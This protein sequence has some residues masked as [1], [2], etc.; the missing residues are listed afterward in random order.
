M[1]AM[2]PNEKTYCGHR[3]AA[4]AIVVVVRA[5]HSSYI[6]DPRFDLAGHSP[7]GFEWGYG[8]SGPAQ[9]ALAILADHLKDEPGRT[10]FYAEQKALRLYQEFK[11]RVI[12]KL[13]HDYWRLTTLEIEDHLKQM[14]VE[15]AR[16]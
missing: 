10:K 14:E 9:L 12:A 7:T 3:T 4:S 5:D 15:A 6:L 11:F 1:T 16:A 13:P 2:L 8:G